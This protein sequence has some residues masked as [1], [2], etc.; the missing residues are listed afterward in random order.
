MDGKYTSSSRQRYDRNG[1]QPNFG[2]SFFFRCPLLTLLVIFGLVFFLIMAFTNRDSGEEGDPTERLSQIQTQP[3]TDPKNTPA[4]TDSTP[5]E[6][7]V[8]TEETV[9]ITTTTEPVTT[10]PPGPVMMTVDEKYFA[11][12]LF[13][14][15]SRT[16]GLCIYSDLRKYSHYHYPADSTSLTIYGIMAEEDKNQRYGYKTTRDLLKGMQFGKI[17][18]MF[19]INEC[20]NSTA[21][22]A[23]EYKK[24]VDEIRSY[25]PDAL[26]YI[27]S[28]GYVTQ[29]R[30]NEQSVF[31]SS[32]IKEKNEA[33]KLLAN[34]VD[35]FYLEV[36][37]CLNDGT[38]HLPADWSGPD[39]AHLKPQYYDYWYQYLLEHAVVDAKHPWSPDAPE[40]EGAQVEHP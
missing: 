20:G 32:N 4:P 40:P 15:D 27:Q 21:S 17:Y 8:T 13:L 35:I 1:R 3:S 18:I 7:L 29:K 25:Q 11:D 33:I 31:A 34:D 2:R 24:V 36:N 23:S 30:E 26:I 37:D 39:G 10:E 6:T 5:P 14:G 22:F 38:D 16:D 19:G 28:I 9:P 12:A